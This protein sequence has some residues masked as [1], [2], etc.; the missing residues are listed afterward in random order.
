MGTLDENYHPPTNMTCHG[1]DLGARLATI[2]YSQCPYFWNLMDDISQK[3]D[4]PTCFGLFWGFSKDTLVD[5]ANQ[6]H[7]FYCMEKRHLTVVVVSKLGVP[8]NH[9]KLHK[10]S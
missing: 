9:P 10:I 6:Q 3:C 1:H 4:F 8:P 5:L 7:I 2:S